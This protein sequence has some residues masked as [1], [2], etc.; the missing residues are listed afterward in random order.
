[1]LMYNHRDALK[2]QIFGRFYKI[3]LLTFQVEPPDEGSKSSKLLGLVPALISLLV[4]VFRALY[5]TFMVGNSNVG[6]LFIE[7]KRI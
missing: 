1:M 4:L 7:L 3:A 2:Q 6:Y 5:F